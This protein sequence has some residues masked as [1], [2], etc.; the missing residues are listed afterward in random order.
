MTGQTG[1]ARTA[2]VKRIAAPIGTTVPCT[3]DVE[4]TGPSEYGRHE[5]HD[6]KITVLEAVRGNNAWNL[7][8]AADDSNSPPD[9]G[10]D[11]LLV[12]IRFDYS[13]EGSQGNMP[14]TL[15]Q[16]CFKL[17]SS[18]NKEYAVPSIV[19]VRPVLVGREFYP[20]SSHEGWIPFMA[21]INDEPV[22]FYPHGGAWFR[23]R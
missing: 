14:Y 3:I 4:G 6:V 21:A 17:Y 8:R 19:S 15:N 16:D 2:P 1:I 11:Y 23:L 10:F 9:T 20:G 22:L 7:I 18:D 12:R 5:L 13:V